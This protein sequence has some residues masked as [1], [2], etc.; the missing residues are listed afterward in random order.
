MQTFLYEKENK[1]AECLN[2][3][4]LGKSKVNSVEEQEDQDEYFKR[5]IESR[6]LKY[7]RTENPEE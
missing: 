5:F 4:T 1:Q 2:N 7:S 6:K 3:F